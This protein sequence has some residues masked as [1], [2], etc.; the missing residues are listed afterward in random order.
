MADFQAIVDGLLKDAPE[1]A[2]CRPTV[3]K[4]LLHLEPVRERVDVT[5]ATS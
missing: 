2:P 4:E 3:E 5:V 1:L